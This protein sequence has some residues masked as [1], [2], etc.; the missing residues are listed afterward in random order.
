MEKSFV[1]TVPAWQ[2]W[3]KH[4]PTYLLCYSVVKP[5]HRLGKTH[6][7][8]LLHAHAWLTPSVKKVEYAPICDIDFTTPR[9]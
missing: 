7:A 4:V 9:K 2:V 3:E 8:L 6:P 5:T 1:H